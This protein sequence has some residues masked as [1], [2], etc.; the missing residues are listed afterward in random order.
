MPYQ[1]YF[2]AYSVKTTVMRGE[3]RPQ[4]D[5]RPICP[6]LI[7]FGWWRWAYLSYSSSC[8]V[9]GGGGPIL[10]I[11]PHF[12]RVV[13][14]EAREPGVLAAR[15]CAA[16]AAAAPPAASLKL[17]RLLPIALEAADT[18]REASNVPD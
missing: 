9:C 5:A 4:V 2:V 6:I 18:P 7:S 13:E 12:M 8:R 1:S 10:P 15:R 16:M 11:H 3:D 14:V 17:L